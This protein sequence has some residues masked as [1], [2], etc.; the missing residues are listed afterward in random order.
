MSEAYEPDPRCPEC[1]AI[2]RTSAS[3]CK[4]CGAKLIS[5]ER[6]GTLVDEDDYKRE[7]G[8][9]ENCWDHITAD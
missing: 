9:C 6:C 3:E 4:K 2:L 1:D 8:M 5:C 7:V